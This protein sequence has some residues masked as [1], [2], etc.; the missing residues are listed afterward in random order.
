[1]EKVIFTNSVSFVLHCNI[2]NKLKLLYLNI[3]IDT[4]NML[5]LLEIYL[6]TI[7]DLNYNRNF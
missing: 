3:K 5:I 1:M 4:F 6:Q 7:Y 2:I